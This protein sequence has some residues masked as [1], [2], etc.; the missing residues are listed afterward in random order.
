MTLALEKVE[1]IAPRD[2]PGE[3]CKRDAYCDVSCPIHVRVQRPA[4][5]HVRVGDDGHKGS[6]RYDC[7]MDERIGVLPPALL[8]KH[9]HF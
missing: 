2:G 6:Y 3:M 1:A 7:G 4:L 9:R 8:I 5:A